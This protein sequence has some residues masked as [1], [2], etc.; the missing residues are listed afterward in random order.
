[1]RAITLLLALFTLPALIALSGCGAEADTPTDS[2]GSEPVIYV[3]YAPEFPLS[4]RDR[5]RS[6]LQSFRTVVELDSDQDLS[7]LPANSHVLVFGASGDWGRY[8]SGPMLNDASEAFA[9]RSLVLD[10][11]TRVSFAQGNPGG[12]KNLLPGHNIGNLYAAYALLEA[13][14]WSFLHPLEPTPPQQPDWDF[15]LGTDGH[16]GLNLNEQP[17]WPIRAWHIHTQHPLELTHVLNGWGPNGPDDEAG[18]QSLLPEWERFLEWS[19]ANR[20]NR[21]EWFLLM[22]ESWQAFAD[23]PQRQQRLRTLVQIAHDWGLAVGIDAPIVFRQQH[24]WTMVRS[25]GNEAAQIRQSIDWLHQA[26]FDYFEIEMGFSEFTHPDAEQMLAW[27]NEAARYSWEQYGK[28]TYVKVHCTQ[29]QLAEGFTDPRNGEPLNFNFLPYYADPLLGV[30]PHT[31]QYYDVQGPAYTYGNRD[32]QFMYDYLRLEAGRREVLYY[33]ET[34]YWV[35]YD[36]D[37]PLFLPIYADRR[38]FDLRLIARDDANGEPIQGQVNF[39]SG[40]EWGYWLNDVVTARAAWNPLTQIEDQDAAL[41]QALNVVVKPFGDESDA[42]NR[43]LRQWIDAQNALFIHGEVDGTRPE[44]PALRNAQAYLQGWEAWDHVAMQLG[45]L[46]TQPRKMGMLEM[47]N[48]LLPAAK[49]IDYATELQPLLHATSTQLGAIL[50]EFEQLAAGIPANGRILYDELRDAM[51]ITVLRAE[52]VQ[53]LYATEHSRH[54][55]DLPQANLYLNRARHALDRAL[56]IT[57]QRE[58]HYRTDPERIASWH[59]NPTAYHFGYLWSVRTLHYWWR[60]EGMVVDRPR[61][62]GYLNIMDPV[63][64]A[65]GEGDWVEFGVNL[66]QLRHWISLLSSDR[67]WFNS[68]LF[69]PNPEY[70][71]P[72]YD[73]RS[74]PDWYYPLAHPTE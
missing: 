38:L 69:E 27:M 42:A 9:L 57:A 43:L 29:D 21:V 66:S 44:E 73:L 49:K 52:Q 70:H 41:A 1:M 46:E 50:A 47:H 23:S 45:M 32:F 53:Y 33:P 13:M 34:A 14:G 31:V 10:N 5:I 12:E 35:S 39:S 36:I 2:A 17:H 16:T 62:P 59:Y 19:V 74:R 11:G 51:A 18:W 54:Q 60:D 8:G 68:L 22:A 40:W 71:Y 30:M 26:G 7:A 64:L 20:Q 3:K 67:S 37:V 24:A 25:A 6:H 72:Q 61:N 15:T 63:D 65:N 55:Q 58:S 48:P 56:A 28:R 4:P